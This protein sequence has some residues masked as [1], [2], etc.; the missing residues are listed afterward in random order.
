MEQKKSVFPVSSLWFKLITNMGFI[1]LGMQALV[2]VISLFIEL[3]SFEI[4]RT[5]IPE[6][7]YSV[8]IA[9]ISGLLVLFPSYLIAKKIYYSQ[10]NFF[11]FI[12][13]A[14]PYVTPAPI[15]GM[16]MISFWKMNLGLNL[17]VMLPA[18][19]CIIRFL[20]MAVLI[21]YFQLKAIDKNLIEAANIFMVGQIK[22]FYK[23]DLPILMPAFIA[24]FGIVF[25]FS[26]GELGATL[27]VIP[28]GSNT[29]TIKLYNYLHYGASDTVAALCLAMLLV[30]FGIYIVLGIFFYSY[31][32]IFLKKKVF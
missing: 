13:L 16:A 18:M 31:K 7:K 9:A 24:A 20:P 30:I 22:N 8:I 5:S 14:L 26:I 12:L 3:K 15:I 2:P 11:W 1:I 29:L 17:G 4:V 27:L 23:I 32:M 6:I 28:A 21:L 10:N 19:A 25:G